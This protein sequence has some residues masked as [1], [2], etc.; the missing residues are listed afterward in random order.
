VRLWRASGGC[1]GLVRILLP[2]AAVACTVAVHVLHSAWQLAP[3]ENA[4]ATEHK[5]GFRMDTSQWVCGG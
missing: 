3:T 1:G 4:A 5:Q 2:G